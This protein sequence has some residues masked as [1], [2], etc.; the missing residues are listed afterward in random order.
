MFDSMI[1][2]WG[3]IAAV[4]A[5]GVALSACSEMLSREDFAARV[6]DKSD[7][8]VKREVGT[9]AAINEI[10]PDQVAWTYNSRT[11]NVE[12]RNKFD[13]KTV[14]VFSKAGTDGK[15]R[16]VDVKFE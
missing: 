15:L 9:P 12:E 1:S 13:T 10:A 2:K 14:V 5:L 3:R 4:M 6:K 11:F 7:L 16:A 8:E